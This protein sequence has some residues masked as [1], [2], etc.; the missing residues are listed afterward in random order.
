M[1]IPDP[2]TADLTAASDRCTGQVTRFPGA[3]PRGPAPDNCRGG[4]V[5]APHS[6]VTSTSLIRFSRRRCG[7]GSRN[8]PMQRASN[9]RDGHYIEPMSCESSGNRMPVEAP[10]EGISSQEDRERTRGE[11]AG[12]ND[13]RTPVGQMN[14]RTPPRFE[15][16]RQGQRATP[17]QRRLPLRLGTIPTSSSSRPLLLR[18]AADRLD[19]LRRYRHQLPSPP[20]PSFGSTLGICFQ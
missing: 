1:G 19:S 15:T 18:W 10:G 2:P 5:P 16:A 13:I 20:P 11:R 12:P 17:R 3:G 4:R 14:Q 8:Q 6:N 7:P 9:R